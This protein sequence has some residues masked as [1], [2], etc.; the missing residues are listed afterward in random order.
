MT[1]GYG[2]GDETAY[3]LGRSDHG[4]ISMANERHDVYA[5]AD[6]RAREGI[7]RWATASPDHFEGRDDEFE[8]EYNKRLWTIVCLWFIPC[9]SRRRYYSF[10]YEMKGLHIKMN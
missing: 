1:T 3:G 8:K 6:E 7:R 5:A 2:E 10:A 9:L 4:R